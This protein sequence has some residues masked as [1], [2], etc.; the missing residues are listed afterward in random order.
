MYLIGG[1][2]QVDQPITIDPI[3]M[4]RIGALTILKVNMVSMV[5]MWSIIKLLEVTIGKQE[6][7]VKPLS[8]KEDGVFLHWRKQS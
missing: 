4:H 7:F 8:T 1:I 3:H 5:I 6:Q 2:V